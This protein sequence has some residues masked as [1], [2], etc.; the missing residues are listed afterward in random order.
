MHMKSHHLVAL[1]MT[2]GLIAAPA[3]A[4]PTVVFSDDFED[5]N[6]VGWST[7][8]SSGAS[9]FSPINDGTLGNAARLGSPSNNQTFQFAAVGFAEQALTNVGDKLSLEFD[10]RWLATPA[11]SGS[12]L[13]FG[14]WDSNGDLTSNA[15]EN[16]WAKISTS[17][18][19]TSQNQINKDGSS[20][21]GFVFNAIASAGT[22]AQFGQATTAKAVNLV[23]E[24]SAAGV[25]IDSTIFDADGTTVLGFISFEDTSSPF[26]TFDALAF[27]TPLDDPLGFDN[28]TV[29]FT[30]APTDPGTGPNDPAPAV[31][32]PATL[33]LAALASLTLL[34]RRPRR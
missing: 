23:L 11:T 27:R 4:V 6:T 17:A 34:R 21:P 19:A 7:A 26:T 28:V 18:T 13:R 15:G 22:G 5:G 9:T 25:Q 30:P 14:L 12:A 33:G 1:G 8:L 32:E 3:L 29:T 16:Y 10:F 20:A 2:I 24:R 31:P